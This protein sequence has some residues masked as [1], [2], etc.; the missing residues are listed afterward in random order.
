MFGSND[1]MR[2]ILD[3]LFGSAEMNGTGGYRQRVVILLF[4]SGLICTDLL[5][6]TI[7]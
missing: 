3:L 4:V 2:L 1:W 7:E 5:L 6:F